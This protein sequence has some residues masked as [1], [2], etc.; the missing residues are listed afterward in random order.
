MDIRALAMGLAFAL[1]WSSAFTSARIIVTEAPPLSALALRFAVSG[2]LAVGLALLRGERWRMA[3][4][5][6]RAIVLFGLCQNALYLGFN[7]VAMQWIEASVAAII[8]STMPLL[9]ALLG[10]V[11]L[12]ERLPALGITG[13]VMGFA[14]VAVIMGSRADLG[15]VDGT[16]ALFCV[17]GALALAVATLTVKGA[18]SGGNVLMSVGMQMFVGSLA[19]LPLA[20]ALE[21]WDVTWD[22]RFTLAFAY[23]TVVPG[24]LATL[25]WFLLVQRIGAV[26]AATFHFLNPFFGVATAA[27]ILS[28]AMGLWDIV[29]VGIIMAG[30]LAV[31]VSR[32]PG[33]RPT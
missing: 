20:L 10:W 24:V 3:P 17:L 13:L 28:E 16:G 9:V 23:T 11:A 14:G 15:G 5:Q 32:K 7:F 33:P 26:R 2:G 31:Q 21:T 25:I 29:G 6:W 4:G 27:A 18:T 1:M 30:I 19:L 22:L 12:R 8:A